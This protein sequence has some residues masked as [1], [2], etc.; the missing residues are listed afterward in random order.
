MLIQLKESLILSEDFNDI[1]YYLKEMLGF[2]DSD[3]FVFLNEGEY[4]SYGNVPDKEEV[5]KIK[6]WADT[7]GFKEL[8]IRIHF[9]MITENI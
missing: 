9:I 3:G 4:Y 6:D 2:I 1:I 7:L 5:L 8:F